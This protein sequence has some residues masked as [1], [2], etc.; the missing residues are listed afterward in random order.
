[1]LNKI[2]EDGFGTTLDIHTS[3]LTSNTPQEAE[4]VLRVAREYLGPEKV[5]SGTLPFRASEDFGFYTQAR[6]GAF[7]FWCTRKQENEVFL[8]NSHFDFKDELIPLAAPFWLKLAQDR[9][10]S[11]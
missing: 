3:C 11:E 10:L 1:M 2:K 8:H 7:F 4:H 6:P 9:L 5:S